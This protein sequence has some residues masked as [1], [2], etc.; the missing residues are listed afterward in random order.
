MHV[1]GEQRAPDRQAGQ[2]RRRRRLPPIATSRRPKAVRRTTHADQR[3]A[4]DRQR[5]APRSARPSTAPLPSVS[6]VGSKISMSRPSAQHQGEPA[7]GDQ[8]AERGDD[9]LDADERDQRAVDQ[10]RPARP[11]ASAIAIAGHDAVAEVERDAAR[12]R[13]AI[14]EPTDRS[15]PSVPMTRAM[16]S[17][18]IATGTTCTSC[19][20]RLATVAKLGVNDQVEDQQHGDRHV[21]PVS[22]SQRSTSARVTGAAGTA[23][24]AIGR[25]SPRPRRTPPR[26]SCMMRSSLISSPRS[27]PTTA[28]SRSTSTRSAPSTTSSSSEEMSRTPSP[29]AASSSMSAWISALAPTSMPRVG[30]SSSSTFGCRQSI[31]AS[32]TFCWLP[33][34]SSRTR[35]SGLEI[36]IRSRRDEGVDEL[37][38]GAARR[39]TR[40]GSAAA[41]RPARCCR[42]PTG[43]A[44]MPSALRSSGTMPMPAPDGRGRRPAPRSAAP[45]DADR[46]GVDRVARRRSPWPSRCGPE[47]SRP[48]RPTT[49]PGVHVDADVG[50]QRAGG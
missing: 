35:W 17:A 32:S 43:P 21:D 13:C 31:R 14:T 15:M 11:P 20:R 24:S 3:R 7:A 48:A 25:P 18:T 34:D 50:E 9:R 10:R 16:P 28:P 2:R 37:V 26:S 40:P 22:R 41:G 49:S 29:C 5:P 4:S 30:S 19:R 12:R 47:P 42:G 27:V 39:R 23:V 8:H 46:P 1:D 45:S 44:M 33:P 36:L 38:A 6:R